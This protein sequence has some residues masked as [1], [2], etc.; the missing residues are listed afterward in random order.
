VEGW[1]NRL[2][3]PSKVGNHWMAWSYWVYVL[4]YAARMIGE[5]AAHKENRNGIVVMPAVLAVRAT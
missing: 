5:Q 4:E 1:R 3:K 2:R